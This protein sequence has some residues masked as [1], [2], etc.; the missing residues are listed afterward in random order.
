M[1]QWY[2]IQDSLRYEGTRWRGVS[3]MCLKNPPKSFK[4]LETDWD[5]MKSFWMVP[6]SAPRFPPPGCASGRSCKS[7]A[8]ASSALQ[9]GDIGRPVGLQVSEG[10]LKRREPTIDSHYESSS[11]KTVCQ[12]RKQTVV[13]VFTSQL[14]EVQVWITFRCL[15]SKKRGRQVREQQLRNEAEGMANPCGEMWFWVIQKGLWRFYGFKWTVVK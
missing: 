14:L 11:N 2:N 4:R 1:I 15:G 13:R 3:K 5:L 12:K 7:C 8:C 9:A 10:H 6:V